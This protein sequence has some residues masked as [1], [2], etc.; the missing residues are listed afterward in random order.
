MCVCVCVYLQLM[1]YSTDQLAVSYMYH[2]YCK[3]LL[4]IS[5]LGMRTIWISG[6][7]SL[8]ARVNSLIGFDFIYSWGGLVFPGCKMHATLQTLFL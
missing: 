2:P 3:D 1:F 7:I 4:G 5:F 6:D 8:I